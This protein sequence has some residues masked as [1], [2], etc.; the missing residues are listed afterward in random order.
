MD[1]I[2]LI[3]FVL[4]VALVTWVGW[5]PTAASRYELT[6]ELEFVIRHYRACLILTA[7]LTPFLFFV[8]PTY[9]HAPSRVRSTLALFFIAISF[10]GNLL[11]GHFLNP[12]IES[13]SSD[14][15][16]VQDITRTITTYY[17][18]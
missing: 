7:L 17:K 12:L 1:M 6:Q 8:F 10:G 5:F 4:V 9:R 15:Q 13:A 11:L 16:R 14:W 18:K 2:G 3:K